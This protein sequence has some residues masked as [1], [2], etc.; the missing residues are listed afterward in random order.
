MAF[1]GA[2]EV[3]NVMAT[4]NRRRKSRAGKP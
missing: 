1:A 4:R 2:V 3:F